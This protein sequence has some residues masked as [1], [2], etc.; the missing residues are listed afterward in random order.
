[1]SDPPEPLVS[2]PPPGAP[3]RP[4]HLHEEGGAVPWTG[5]SILVVVAG[6]ILFM[7]LPQR[8]LSPQRLL[9]LR[10]ELYAER[11][12]DQLALAIQDYRHDHGAWPGARP[13]A[14]RGL[15]PAV[16]EGVWFERQLRLASDDLGRVAPATSSAYPHGPYLPGGVPLNPLTGLRTVRL[17]EECESFDAIR[18]GIYGWLYDPRSGELRAH[19]LPILRKH[20]TLH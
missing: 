2:S 13:T 7:A 3:H 4:P 15:A 5:L 20:A 19:R 1:M 16:Y 6:L 17:L 11:A 18:D 9:E 8:P 10:A 14:E 12:L